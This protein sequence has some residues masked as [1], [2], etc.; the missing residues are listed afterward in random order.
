ML[1][2][3]DINEWNS[4]PHTTLKR[5]WKSDG[6]KSEGWPSNV[7]LPFFARLGSKEAYESWRKD[8]RGCSFRQGREGDPSCLQK[9]LGHERRCHLPGLSE[10]ASLEESKREPSPGKGH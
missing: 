5:L 4:K 1:G 7:I 10:D 2:Y 9:F 8:A 3:D 6:D